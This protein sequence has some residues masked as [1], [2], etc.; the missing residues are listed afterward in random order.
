[1]SPA[2]IIALVTACSLVLAAVALAASQSI[3]SRGVGPVHVGDKYLSLRQAGRLGKVGPGC[4]LAG[5][6]ARSAPLVAPAQ[7]SVD[8]SFHSPRKV[9]NIT[10]TGGATA[11][12]VGIGDKTADVKAAYKHVRVDHSTDAMFGLTL[13]VVTGSDGGSRIAFAVDT[14][15]KKITRIG[16]PYLAECE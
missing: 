7:G 6:N 5:P 12:G 9:T 10:V 11:R 14:G 8:L 3:T 13:V 2:R 4:E 1:M 16:I 15:T